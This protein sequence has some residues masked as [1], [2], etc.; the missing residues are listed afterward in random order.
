ME[1]IT[2]TITLFILGLLIASLIKLRDQ[3]IIIAKLM[4]E[5]RN[6]KMDMDSTPT[7]KK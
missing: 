5:I 3:S 4:K 2:L 6:L 7:I 1:C